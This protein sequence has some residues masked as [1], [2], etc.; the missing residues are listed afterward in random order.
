MAPHF[1]SDRIQ[2]THRKRRGDG[3]RAFLEQ[4]AHCRSTLSHVAKERKKREAGMMRRGK[5]REEG[6]WKE[7]STDKVGRGEQAERRHKNTGSQA[8]CWLQKSHCFWETSACPL[9]PGVAS[10]PHSPIL[11]NGVER[12]HAFPGLLPP[13]RPP[14]DLF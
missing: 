11:G 8:G 4:Q 14:L 1:T 12:Q 10:P 7:S 5:K 9:T 6:L 3:A 2:G 13:R